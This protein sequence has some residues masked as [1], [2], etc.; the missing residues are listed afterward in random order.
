[1]T[2]TSL[3]ARFILQKA[4]LVVANVFD[5]LDLA[6]ALMLPI[7]DVVAGVLL[8]KPLKERLIFLSDSLSIL[9]PL[10]N[11]QRLSNGLATTASHRF[12][13]AGQTRCPLHLI[14]GNWRHVTFLMLREVAARSS[15]DASHALEQHSVRFLNLRAPIYKTVEKLIYRSSLNTDHA[16]PNLPSIICSFLAFTMG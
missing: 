5:Q 4:R 10:C 9:V 16:I 2:L 11:I 12:I 6:F 3:L 14:G 8:L 1:M 7:V 13:T 15:Q